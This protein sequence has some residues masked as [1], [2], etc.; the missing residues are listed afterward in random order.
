MSGHCCVEKFNLFHLFF[1]PD[2][3][4]NP[5]S[6]IGD[7]LIVDSTTNIPVIPMPTNAIC[8]PM[9]VEKKLRENSAG[10]QEE[11]VLEAADGRCAGPE[12]DS[13]PHLY[14]SGSDVSA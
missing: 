7:E 12:V 8:H 11:I 13:M 6:V 14:P 5:S 3:I 1:H 2:S 10:N 9:H 4:T